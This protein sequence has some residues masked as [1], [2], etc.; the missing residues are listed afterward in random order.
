MWQF[1]RAKNLH[2]QQFY[3]FSN[4]ELIN[5]VPQITIFTEDA[6]IYNFLKYINWNDYELLN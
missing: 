1:K 6:K 5:S 3:L 4:D 2:L